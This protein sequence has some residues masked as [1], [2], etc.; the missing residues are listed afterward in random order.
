MTKI[1]T[2]KNR[3]NVTSKKNLTIDGHKDRN[4][5]TVEEL[6]MLLAGAAKT[7]NPVRNKAILLT[8]FW[9]GLRVSELCQL[10]I[11]D[12]DTRHG[13]LIVNRLKHSLAT[14]HPVRPEVLRIIKQYLKSRNSSIR[15]LFLNERNDQ[16]VRTGINHLLKRCS[17]LGGLP[18]PVNPHMLRHGCGF[19]LANMGHDTRLI[20]DYLGHKEIRHT[21]IY[22]R[23]SAK[24]FEEIWD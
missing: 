14:T 13:R 6:G 10:K 4:F 11:S 17:V 3:R 18:F 23:T 19:A 16:F 2:P 22:T 5:I 21:V 24:R 8:M 12:L 15:T 20:Q 1:N 9:H 7:R